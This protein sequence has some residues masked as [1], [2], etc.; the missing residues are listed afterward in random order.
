M[1]HRI[2]TVLLL[3]AVATLTSWSVGCSMCCDTYDYDYPTYGGKHERADP[4]Y[5]RLGSIFS[6]PGPLG[7]GPNADSNRVEVEDKSQMR[8]D[9]VDPIYNNPQDLPTPDADTSPQPDDQARRRWENQPLRKG[10]Q[11]R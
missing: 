1:N 11:W 9:I 2:K 3:L 5:G 8:N 4:V 6:D 7:L 10:Q